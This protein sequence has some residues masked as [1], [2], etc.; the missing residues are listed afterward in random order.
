MGHPLSASGSR[1]H[2]SLPG[3]SLLSFCVQGTLSASSNQQ[4]LQ[5]L[6]RPAIHPSSAPFCFSRHCKSPSPA[7]PMGELI[8]TKPWLFEPKPK[9]PSAEP[10]LDCLL[11]VR[12]PPRSNL[13]KEGGCSSEQ[14]HSCRKRLFFR[15]EECGWSRQ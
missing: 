11:F 3:H 7:F 13:L 1:R 10:P 15:K 5:N 2:S 8:T 12:S 6:R 14:C 4:H 9:V